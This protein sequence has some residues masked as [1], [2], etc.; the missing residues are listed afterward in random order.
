MIRINLLGQTRPKTARRPADT[1]AALP[2]VFIGAG[3]LLGGLVLFYFYHS[4]Q[5]QLNDETNRI[6]QLQS[7][8]TELE[9][10]KLQVES[11]E[12]QKQVLQQRVTTIE[13]LQHDRTGGQE[14][15]DQV[16]NTVSRAENLWLTSMSKK[17]STL[18]IDGAAASINSVANFIT[19]LKRSGYFQKIEIKDA[20]QDDKN[21]AVQTFLFTINAEITPSG[22]AAAAPQTKPASAPSPGTPNSAAPAKKG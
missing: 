6:K 19:A 1:G 16:A 10:I 15:L 22:P 2:L 17:G 3:V 12:K 11:F 8:K 21:A 5:T 14:L 4:W 20:K 13:Q 7:Q 18:T 9:Q